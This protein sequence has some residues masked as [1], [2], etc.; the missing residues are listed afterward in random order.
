[1][2]AETP[3]THW[4]PGAVPVAVVMISLNE[5]HNME[6]VFQNEGRVFFVAY[7]LRGQTI[8]IISARKTNRREVRGS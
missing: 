6:A 2:S 1:M 4:Q 7:I 8:R 5:A 3:P